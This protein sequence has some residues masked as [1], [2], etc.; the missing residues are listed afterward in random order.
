[1]DEV[2]IISSYSVKTYNYVDKVT[3]SEQ[4][5]FFSLELNALEKM[6]QRIGVQDEALIRVQEHG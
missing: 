2:L 4:K 5:V 1:M 3:I 6:E